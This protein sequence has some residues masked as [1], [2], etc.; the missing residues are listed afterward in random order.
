M[1]RK[2][3]TGIIT[4]ININFEYMRTAVDNIRHENIET[5]PSGAGNNRKRSKKY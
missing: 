1:E 4:K 5:L 2:I 3:I